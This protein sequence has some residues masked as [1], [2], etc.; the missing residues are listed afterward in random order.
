MESV[1][2]PDSK[3]GSAISV[4]QIAKEILMISLQ[5]VTFVFRSVRWPVSPK[6]RNETFWRVSATETKPKQVSVDH[7]LLPAKLQACRVG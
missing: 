6:Q 5:I 1:S 4:P 7:Y 2:S 3:M